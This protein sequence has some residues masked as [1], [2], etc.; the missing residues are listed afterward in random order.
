MK[1]LGAARGK[2]AKAEGP[3]PGS[4]AGIVLPDVK[5]G[6]AS[7]SYAVRSLRLN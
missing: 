1:T 4:P 5:G 3:T 7:G 6:P 2:G